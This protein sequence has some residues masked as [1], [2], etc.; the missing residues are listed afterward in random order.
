MANSKHGVLLTVCE[1]FS[2]TE[3]KNR[4]FCQLY[5][6]CRPIAE[7]RTAASTWTAEKYIQWATILSPTIRVYLHSFTRC[8]IQN[9]RN[10]AK[11]L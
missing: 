7:E 8:C 1:I 5:C 11:F 2:R 9:V 6:D 3:L 10:R 4:H